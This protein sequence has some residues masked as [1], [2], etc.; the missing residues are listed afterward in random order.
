MYVSSTF[1][2]FFNRI[3]GLY[4][5]VVLVIGRL[6]RSSVSSLPADLLLDEIVNPEKLLKLCN[7][8]FVVRE[9]RNFELEEILVG[10]LFAIFRSPDKLIEVTENVKP[11]ED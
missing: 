5:S 11:K 3:I 9:S 10:K 6:I 4:V 1:I 7:D 8:I 2:I